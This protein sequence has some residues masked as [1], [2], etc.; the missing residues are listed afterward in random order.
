MEI[1]NLAVED[2][3]TMEQCIV[4]SINVKRHKY[5]NY[6]RFKGKPLVLKFCKKTVH[7]QDTVFPGA[8]IKDT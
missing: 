3:R 8:P 6:P 4:Y 7:E 1:E 5:S 2:V